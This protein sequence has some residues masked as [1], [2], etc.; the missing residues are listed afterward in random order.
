MLRDVVE[1]WRAVAFVIVVLL[2]L[3]GC[4]AGHTASGPV[5]AG[6][7][8]RRDAVVAFGAEPVNLDFTRTS[9]A[10][11]PQLLLNNVYET[12]VKIGQ[13]GEIQPLLAERWEISADR[14]TYDFF[15]VP[16]VTFSDGRPF[17]SADVVASFERTQTDWLNAIAGSMA[18]IESAEAISETQVRVTLSRPSNQWLFTLGTAAGAIFPAELDF[19]LATTAI[20]T[21]PF[22]VSQVAPG[23]HIILSGRSDYWGAPPALDSVTVRYFSDPTAAVNAL[24]AGDV[25]L[26]LN[27]ATGDQFR[28]LEQVAG[29]QVLVGT[30]T[31]EVLWSF[32]NRRFPDV[33]VRQAF[34]YAVDRE[35]VLAALTADFGILLGSMVTP[36]DPFF[37]DLSQVFPY[38]PDRA[39]E[40]LAEAGAVD[41]TVSLDVP[42]LPYAMQA[43]EIIQAYLAQ[44]GVTAAINVLEFPAVWLEQVF[45]NHDF[46][47]SVIMHSEAWDLLTVFGSPDYYVGYDN[48]E[49]LRQA[50]LADSGTPEQWVA[51]MR[52]VVREIVADVPAVVLY[53]APTL[54]AANVGLTGIAVNAVTESFDLTN[55]G[56]H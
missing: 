56:W 47:M 8:D 43:A 48:P 37:E 53:L 45:R 52:E 3:S 6:T 36:Q 30:S 16:G 22:E 44:V 38:D 46:D 4:Y 39:R 7:G 18:I 28:A 5:F 51:G 1:R 33:R 35:A 17:T 21:G 25:D 26:I 27:L 50:A 9:G 31:G 19:D 49:V 11:I 15:L 41:L 2:T 34:A 42:S 23:S 24:R 20:G 54:V 10:A 32:N 13:N 12:L 40:L 29:L 14:L 55:L